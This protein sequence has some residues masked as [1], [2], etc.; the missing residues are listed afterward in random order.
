MNPSS[1][2]VWLSGIFEKQRGTFFRKLAFG[3]AKSSQAKG[4]SVKVLWEWA[5]EMS[6]SM[7][8]YC[9]S[10]AIFQAKAGIFGHTSGPGWK[11]EPLVLHPR[12]T[13]SQLHHP[14]GKHDR[15]MVSE[16]HQESLRVGQRGIHLRRECWQG[17]QEKQHGP[18]NRVWWVCPC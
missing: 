10:R 16:F 1:L 7:P 9:F 18:D 12:S 4:L 5:P 8:A 13:R 6:H 3:S 14:E 15:V 2:I 17:D 11:S